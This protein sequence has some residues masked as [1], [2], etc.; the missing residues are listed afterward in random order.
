MRGGSDMVDIGTHKA[1]VLT[2]LADEL[3]KI[4][5]Q[6]TNRQCLLCLDDKLCLKLCCTDI[7]KECFPGNF[8]N[9]DYKLKCYVCSKI[10]PNE[11]FFK[12]NEFIQSLK[13]LDHTSELV[14]KIDF[15]ICHCGSL[16]LNE[17]MYSKQQCQ[18][19]SRW[20]CFFCSADWDDTRM[21]NQKHTCTV[22]CV[23]ETRLNYQSESW[24]ESTLPNRRCCPKCALCGSRDDK[25]KYHTCLCG[26][27]FCFICLAAKADCEKAHP[28]VSCYNRCTTDDKKQ[29]YSIFPRLMS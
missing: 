8:I 22:N 29:D 1:T 4:P 11:N 28:G 2:D 3:R 9:Y 25:C 18:Q 19:C 21:K 13:K 14:K 16:A 26:H 20:M 12:T 10:V 6:S 27:V 15:Q 17:T 5:V 24:H 7:C 23:W